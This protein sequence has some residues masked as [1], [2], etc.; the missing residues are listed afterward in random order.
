MKRCE[1]KQEVL[2]VGG[3]AVEYYIP[4]EEKKDNTPLLFCHGTG[5]GSWIWSNFCGYFSSRGWDTYAMNYRGHYLSNQLENLG[6]CHFIDYVDDVEAVVNYLKKDPYLFGH[7]LGGIV[8]QKYAERRNPAKL[9]LVD[10]GTCKALTQRLD[11]Q[12]IIRG[13]AEKGVYV[14]KGDL[15]TMTND[16]EK[17]KG[18]LFDET[19]VEEEALR[20]YVQK[21]GW[22]SKQAAM[23]SGHTAVDPGKIRCPVYVIGK[24]NGFST[25][26]PTNQ[27]L[28]EYYHAR[29]IKVFE[30]MGHCFMK[31]KNWE[32]YARI[33][34]HWLLENINEKAHADSESDG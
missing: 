25:G 26:V 11:V 27:W 5:S 9:F 31:E 15:V 22:E 16:L 29:D 4:E 18:F 13:M 19:L 12:T 6:A 21:H 14:E 30:P 3:L 8:V 24:E 20:E 32:L 34:E 2:K 7:S 23:E 28:A 17:I 33:I 10:S 1:M